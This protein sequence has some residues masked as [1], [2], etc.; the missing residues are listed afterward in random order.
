M[1]SLRE[2]IGTAGTADIPGTEGVFRVISPGFSTS[3]AV[4]NVRPRLDEL[5]AVHAALTE[6]EGT[7]RAARV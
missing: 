3:P 5:G 7:A 1:G 2:D 4:E 6:G